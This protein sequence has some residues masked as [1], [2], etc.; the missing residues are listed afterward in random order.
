MS[1]EEV[2]WAREG[3][4]AAAELMELAQDYKLHILIGLDWMEANLA[5]VTSAAH[6]W[7]GVWFT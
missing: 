7:Q 4:E 5:D 1:D 2:T 6:T 3:V